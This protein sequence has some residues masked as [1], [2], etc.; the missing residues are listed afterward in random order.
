MRHLARGLNK[1]ARLFP[2]PPG[3]LYSGARLL[4]RQAMIDRLCSSL[5]V[6]MGK[7]RQVL[8]WTPPVSVDEALRKTA[9]HFRESQSQ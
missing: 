8:G 7:A 2:F 9:R 5:Q 6:D 1:P 4:G 3:L